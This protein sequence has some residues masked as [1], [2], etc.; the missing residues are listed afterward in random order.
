MVILR[1]DRLASGIV[2][3]QGTGPSLRANLL[4]ICF[5]L[6]LI[7]THPKHAP[8]LHAAFP[9]LLGLRTRQRCDGSVFLHRHEERHTPDEG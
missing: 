4:P 9:P 7:T 3:S 5:N 6:A 8:F 1:E 2:I